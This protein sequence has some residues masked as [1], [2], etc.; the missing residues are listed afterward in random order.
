MSN[1]VVIRS[2]VLTDGY[3]V[4]L[5]DG[6]ISWRPSQGRRTNYRL[7]LPATVLLGI[8][9]PTGKCESVLIGDIKG[10]IIRL[11]LPKLDLLDEYV[12]CN[13]SI[14][15]LCRTS[16]TS[17]KI[18]VGNDNGE[19]WLIG[20]DVPGNSVRLF[21]H[22]DKITSIRLNNN[23]I[24]VQCGWSSFKYDWEGNLNAFTDKNELFNKKQKQRA[25]RHKRLLAKKSCR[26]EHACLEILPLY[27]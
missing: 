9:G 7:Q 24:I 1:G 4:A 22:D 15:S 19:V 26:H 5:D 10:N 12:T 11:S 27:G 13:S 6:L 21:I 14:R 3:I 23:E 25:N 17:D 20:N 18:L 2:M 8:T 16:L